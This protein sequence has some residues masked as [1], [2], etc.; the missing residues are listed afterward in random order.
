MTIAAEIRTGMPPAPA[1]QR[2]VGQVRLRAR[3]GP[4]GV[5]RLADLRHAGSLRVV[6]PGGR[7]APLQAVVVNT[8]GGITG[9][10]RFEIAAEAAEGAALTLTTQ[11]C[12]RAYRA[13][14]GQVGRLT[15]RLT[16]GPGARL[17]WLPQE[18]I[19][20]DRAA[21]ARRLD[22]TLAADARFLMVEPL[23]FGRRAMGERVRALRLSDRVAIRRGG[24]P[25][26]RDGIEID[27]DAEALL[28]RPAVAGGGRAVATLLYTAPDAEAQA[29]ALRPTLPDGAAIS[30]LPGDLLALRAV[31]ADGFALRRCLLPVL[32]RLTGGAV[33]TCWRL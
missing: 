21:L 25:L 8:A 10:D 12:E 23:V 27:G 2:A 3:G 9:G 31:A 26:W 32:D 15:T 14:D 22:V 4:G 7:R 13:L 6:F 24:R 30:L 33:P 5:T 16:A 19:L 20:F 11:A 18:T 1:A 17:D 28:D 29:A